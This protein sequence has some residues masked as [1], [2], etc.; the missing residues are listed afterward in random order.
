MYSKFDYDTNKKIR[1]IAQAS[2]AVDVENRARDFEVP[3]GLK[4]IGNTC[5][6]N[7]L[8]QILF[9]LPNFQ[10]KILNYDVPDYLEN[11]EKLEPL[12]RRKIM[13]SRELIRKL[14]KLLSSMLLSNQS[15]Q[16]PSAV[17][18]SIV[19]DKA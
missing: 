1:D 9:F 6:F 7:S 19:N 18:K 2:E 17:M 16:D 8:I 11:A 13:Q 14:Q 5:W 12:E 4:N 3:S 15:Y 10:E